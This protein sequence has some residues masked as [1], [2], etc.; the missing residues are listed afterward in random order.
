MHE[1]SDPTLPFPDMQDPLQHL[2]HEVTH[3]TRMRDIKGVRDGGVAP[4]IP[5]FPYRRLA[6]RKMDIELK[7]HNTTSLH[8]LD[9]L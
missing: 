9:G 7:I 3:A 5:R 1:T 4:E 6:T 2:L 8:F